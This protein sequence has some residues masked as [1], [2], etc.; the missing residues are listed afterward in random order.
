MYL[1]FSVV[2]EQAFESAPGFLVEPIR[3]RV[4]FFSQSAHLAPGQGRV[5]CRTTAD[6][7][8]DKNRNIA[9]NEG[10]CG[11]VLHRTCE[12]IVVAIELE[13]SV[14]EPMFIEQVFLDK[15]IRVRERPIVE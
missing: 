3:E 8:L 6:S 2:E 9:V 5:F 11:P 1:C 10:H 7:V 13:F 15:S 12:E 14:V 4:V